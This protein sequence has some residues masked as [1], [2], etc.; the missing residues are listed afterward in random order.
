MRRHR[1][2]ACTALVLLAHGG[3]LLGASR[4]R[5]AAAFQP[6]GYLACGVVSL[7]WVVALI[8]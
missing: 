1:L 6:A 7:V 2:L 5:A 3:V 4:G 8:A